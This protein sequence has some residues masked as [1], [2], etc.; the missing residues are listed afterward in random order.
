MPI[1]IMGPQL[2]Y[3]DYLNDTNTV[4]NQDLIKTLDCRIG[5]FYWSD[6]EGINQSNARIP[7]FSNSHDLSVRGLNPYDLKLQNKQNN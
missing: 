3:R 2:T 6:L 7:H 5:Q 4:G 1:W